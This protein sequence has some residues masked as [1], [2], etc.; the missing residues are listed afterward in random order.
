MIASVCDAAGKTM[1]LQCDFKQIKRLSLLKTALVSRG[2]MFYKGGRLL[3][4]EYLSPYA[5]TFVLNKDKV[6]LKSSQKTDVVDVKSSRTFQQIARIMMNSITGKCLTDTKYFKVTMYT[7]KKNWMAK[8]VPQQKDLQQFFDSIRLHIDPVQQ[9]VTSV[10]LVEKSG[11]ITT[12][13]MMNV[14]RNISIDD[15]VFNVK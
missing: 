13:E 14:K 15:A 3:R 6:M 10:E 5:Y 9:M 7:L 4:W 11:D 12:I 1:S 8:L 2:R